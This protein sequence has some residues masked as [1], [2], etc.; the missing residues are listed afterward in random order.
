MGLMG[1]MGFMGLN[2]R[3]EIYKSMKSHSL[4]SR[5]GFEYFITSFWKDAS[6]G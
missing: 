3:Y 1:L 5:G 4:R 2:R 6:D